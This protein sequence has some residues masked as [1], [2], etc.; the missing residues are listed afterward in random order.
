[1]HVAAGHLRAHV[2][3]GSARALGPLSPIH[4]GSPRRRTPRHAGVYLAVCTASGCTPKALQASREAGEAGAE[5]RAFLLGRPTGC[6]NRCRTCR[7][8][9]LPATEISREALAYH[10]PLRLEAW[11]VKH[12]GVSKD[13]RRGAWRRRGFAQTPWGL[14]AAKGLRRGPLA[15]RTC[16]PLSLASRGS[17]AACWRSRPCLSTCQ[18]Y[19]RQR[20][21][22]SGLQSNWASAP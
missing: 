11:G 16:A 20:L 22:P 7:G 12:R 18:N 4:G 1:M 8:R 5:R 15:P 13:G 21:P 17:S 3:H 9:C 19:L 2:A 10:A 6:T 14:A